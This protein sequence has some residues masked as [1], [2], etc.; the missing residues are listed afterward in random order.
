MKQISIT[1]VRCYGTTKI[2]ALALAT[3]NALATMWR[4][5]KSIK[6]ATLQLRNRSDHGS[7]IARFA[8]AEPWLDF[9]I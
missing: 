7:T 2:I 4:K 5:I 8:A 9:E 6:Q 3:T 1:P